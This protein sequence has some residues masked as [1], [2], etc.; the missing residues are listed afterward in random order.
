VVLLLLAQVFL[1][2]VLSSPEYPSMGVYDDLDE[3]RFRPLADK[4]RRP[5]YR[6][7]FGKRISETNDDDVMIKWPADDVTKD[8]PPSGEDNEAN[9]NIEEGNHGVRSVQAENEGVEDVFEKRTAREILRSDPGKRRYRADFGKRHPRVS[10]RYPHVTGW[11]RPHESVEGV[12]P[13]AGPAG[14][15][16]AD[17]SAAD[18]KARFRADFGKRSA[19]RARVWGR[20]GSRSFRA[21]FG[22]RLAYQSV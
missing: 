11:P 18:K 10:E 9:L 20:S 13:L 3:P 15:P 7:D 5:S 12:K 8:S 4:R 22:K 17:V 2:S 14:R 6:G 1:S 21:D 16:G 19:P